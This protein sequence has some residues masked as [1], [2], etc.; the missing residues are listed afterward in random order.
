MHIALLGPVSLDDIQ[1]LV[2]SRIASTGYPQPGLAELAVELL[3]RGHQITLITSAT[4]IENIEKH[5]SERFELF[6]LPWRRRHKSR[7]LDLFASERRQIISTLNEIRPDIAHAHWTYEF[8]LGALQSNV[9]TIVSAN[10]APF[11][12]LRNMPDAYRFFRYLLAW[13]VRARAKHLTAISP[14]LAD[15]WVRQML[16]RRPISVITSPVKFEPNP[17]LLEPPQPGIVTSIGN[18]SK[19][20]NLE[21]LIAGFGLV[22]A[23]VN[24]ACL[25]LVGPG[26]EPEGAFA[27]RMQRQYSCE[28]VEFVGKVAHEQIL[29]YLRESSVYCHPSLEESLGL[30]LLEAANAGAS[31]VAGANSGAVPWTLLNGQIGLLVDVTSPPAIAEAILKCLR[32]PGLASVDEKGMESLIRRHSTVGIADSYLANYQIAAS[33]GPT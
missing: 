31:V 19:L 24:F 3:S 13:R 27:R 21:P 22:R 17:R 28:G 9:P 10:D 8:A 7:A 6:V 29:K 11:S 4:D 16:W 5:S 18:P 30:S 12:I 25:R 23:E 33:Q 1:P 2:T 32:D 14:Y 20:K 26:L 15:R